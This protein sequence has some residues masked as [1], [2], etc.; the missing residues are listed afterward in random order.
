MSLQSFL[1]DLDHN[2]DQALH[3]LQLSEK[4]RP[5]HGYDIE[6]AVSPQSFLFVFN[7]KAL[8]IYISSYSPKNS[9]AVTET[10]MAITGLE[11]LSI[12]IGIDSTAA[13]FAN[14]RV[15]NNK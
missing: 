13:A 3:I 12:K 14:R 7:K 11:I 1:K 2:H 8:Y 5:I 10:Q 9:T 4:N 6:I 15:T